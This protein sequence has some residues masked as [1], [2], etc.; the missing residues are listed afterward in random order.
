[1][2]K[3]ETVEEARRVYEESARLDLDTLKALENLPEVSGKMPPVSN[4]V[5][6]IHDWTGRQV[7]QCKTKKQAWD[8]V[9]SRTF[10]GLYEV[11]SP[12][13]LDTGEFVPF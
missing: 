6:I 4:Y 11:H 5:V 12:A 7:I 10:G 8:A 9:G 1:M 3:I 2:R 13:G